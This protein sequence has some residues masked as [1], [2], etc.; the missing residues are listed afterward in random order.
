MRFRITIRGDGTE[1]RGYA[2]PSVTV[3][4][5]KAL[6]QLDCMVVA[7]P[8]DDDYDPFKEKTNE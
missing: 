8:T 2:P 5:A 1:I 3:A 7:S 6:E 4:I